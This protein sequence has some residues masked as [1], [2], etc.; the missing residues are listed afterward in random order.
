M[1]ACPA[2]R[3][4]EALLVQARRAGMLIRRTG[5][6]DTILLVDL[7]VGDTPV[8]RLRAPG[9]EPQLIEDIAWGAEIEVLAF[10]QPARQLAHDRS[11]APRLTWRFDRLVVLDDASLQARHGSFVLG[12]HAA[13]QD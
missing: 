10:A 9:S 3:E 8:V 11:V 12:P 1:E 5:P 2:I 13:R 6:E 7:F 4:A